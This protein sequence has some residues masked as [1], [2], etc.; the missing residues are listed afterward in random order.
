MTRMIMIAMAVPTF[1]MMQIVFT[2]ED[3]ANK[4]D[5][6]YLEAILASFWKVSNECSLG[7]TG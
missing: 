1:A 3:E 2:S 5:E 7:S 4:G 6:L